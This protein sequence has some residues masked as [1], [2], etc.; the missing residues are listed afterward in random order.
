[1]FAALFGDEAPMT[2]PAGPRVGRGIARVDPAD[3]SVQPFLRQPL[4]R[5]IDV[6]FDPSG[7]SLYVVD[8]GQFEMSERGVEA[9]AGTGKLWRL[10]MHAQEGATGE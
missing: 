9:V 8:F 6:R 4:N 1:M 5:P 3:W 10:R 7:E 2:A